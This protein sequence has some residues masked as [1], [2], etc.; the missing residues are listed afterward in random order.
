[1]MKRIALLISGIVLLGLTAHAQI[2]DTARFRLDFRPMI[3]QANKINQ[4]AVIQDTATEKV[5]FDYYITPQRLDISFNPSSLQPV[6]MSA[7]VMKR[8]YRNYLKAGF[9]YPVTPLL[10]LYIHNPDNTKYSYGLNLHHF[11]SWAPPIGKKMRKYPYH[12]TSDTRAHLFFTRFF[13]NQTLYT[14]IGYNH[15]L[16][17]LYGYNR[18]NLFYL[19]DI[20]RYYE[21]S[22]RD[23]INN[24]FHHFK[25][26]AGLRSN[27]VLEDRRL[28]QD[29]RLHYNLIRTHKKDMEN[30]VGL[31]SYFAYDARFLRL[32]GSQNYKLGLDF[33]FYN[34]AWNDTLPGG[35]KRSDNSFRI[36]LKPTVNFTIREYHI[37]FGLG[38]PII[39]NYGTSRVPIYPVAEIQLG[40][41][42]GILSIYAGLDGKVKYNSLQ[43]MLYENPYLKPHIDTLKFTRSQINI[44]GGIKGNLVKKLNYHLSAHYSYDKDMHFFLLDTASKLRN[45]FDIIYR[46]VNTLNVCFNLGW[47]ALDHLYLNLEANYWGYFFPNR[48]DSIQEYAWYKP[49]WEVAFNGRYVYDNRMIFSLNFDLQFGRWALAADH[50]GVFHPEKM[51]PILDFGIGFE[52]LFSKR[53]SAFANISNI[54]CQNYA[55]YHDFKSFGI[56]VLLGITYSFGDESLK[57]RRR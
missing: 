17:N 16:A 7:D 27:Y 56:N 33:D 31:T 49:S 51:S 40:I 20:G 32:S 41:I 4:P 3:Q 54:A 13:R 18:E 48:A 22:Y 45:Q 9:G 38:L 6:K 5:D 19:H 46:N 52:Y 30:H 47:E 1:M 14:S 37:L 44:Y 39:H 21:K 15:Q 11:S 2:I 35:F 26:E 8:L 53:F 24:S 25:A 57:N 34:N 28:K 50:E 43:D 29:V 55:K 10:E 12:P 42:P 36:E 23:T